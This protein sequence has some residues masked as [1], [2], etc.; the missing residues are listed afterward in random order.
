MDPGTDNYILVIFRIPERLQ[1][2]EA[3]IKKQ[4]TTREEMSRW[5]RSALSEGPVVVR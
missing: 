3:L 5:Q 4:P 2:Q 1:G